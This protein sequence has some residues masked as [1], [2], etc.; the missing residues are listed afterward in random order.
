MN[1]RRATTMRNPALRRTRL[2]AVLYALLLAFGAAAA[3]ALADGGVMGEMAMPTAEDVKVGTVRY[4]VP[5]LELRDEA[6]RTV[7]LRELFASKRPVIVNFIFTSCPSICPVMT[8]TLLQLKRQLKDD[9]SNPLF[10][11]ITLD[12]DTDT[13]AVLAEYAQRFDARW[14]FL[15]GSREDVLVALRAFDV[16]RGNKMNHAAVT[17]MR[18]RPG[19]AFTRVEGLASAGELVTV[20][21]GVRG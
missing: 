14:K 9:R 15:T 5:D 16:W 2:R 6:G 13:P 21:K 8:G 18:R 3:P 10:I 1:E 4:E 7:R 11:S 19:D 12:P 17:L 20:W